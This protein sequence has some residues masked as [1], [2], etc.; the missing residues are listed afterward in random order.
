MRPFILTWAAALFNLCASQEQTPLQSS[1]P[2]GTPLSDAFNHR[3]EWALKHYHVPG[4]AIAVVHN[5]K[6]FTQG[7]GLSDL[8]STT[9]VTGNTLFFTGSTTK[10]HTAAAI[11]LLV[12]D[13][14][15]YPHTQ[16]NTPVADLIPGDFALSDPYST[17]HVTLTDMLSHRSGLPR[18]D[19]VLIQ[20]TTVQ[21]IVRKLRH[22]PL[23][24]EIRTEF[25]Y[26]NLM[27]IT[28]GWMIEVVTGMK[29]PVFLKERIWSPLGM[30]ETYMD[31]S[32]AFEDGRDVAQ[33]YYYDAER[34]KTT[35]T[36]RVYTASVH[37]AGNI[38]SSVTDYAKWISALLHQTGP[39][40]SAGYTALFGAHSIISGVVSAPFSAPDLYGF[41]WTLQNYKGRQLIQHGGAQ[42]GFGAF[43]AMM[44]EEK[45]GLVVLGNEMAG[46]SMASLVLAFELIDWVLGVSEEE[47][48]DWEA[49]IDTQL[50]QAKLTNKTMAALYPTLEDVPIEALL[51]HP[52]NLSSYEGIYTHPA[53][54]AMTV[55]ATC[56]D[57]NPRNNPE[58]WT[59]SRLCATFGD[60]DSD[61][62]GLML[63]LFH[64]TGTYWTLV[65][66]SW[67]MKDATR[68]EFQI[69]PD[70]LVTEV[71][72]ELDV[73]MKAK[74]EKI[75]FG[76]G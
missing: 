10:A 57:R 35:S 5:D 7:Y 52:L 17:T 67:G 2:N 63:D 22:L 58:K 72:A 12:D 38:L 29:L 54:P 40:S 6:T 30:N 23:T 69:S 28:A 49:A 70:G 50:Q 26:C 24:A 33:G 3:V 18:H 71:G 15:N 56:P 36:N 34:D 32:P 61:P 27:Y 20:N 68:V 9:P 65:L 73:F 39:I 76:R 53:Y 37:G 11:S 4:L 55:S 62:M 74:G 47:R 46:M 66:G 41:G 51:P 45:F 64:I 59:G 60:F 21:E 13:D 1:S 19:L 8:T 14:T 42:V 48:F 25:Q 44:P 75:W 16:W 31:L 43:V